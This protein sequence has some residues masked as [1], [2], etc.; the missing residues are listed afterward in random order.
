MST[1]DSAPNNDDPSGQGDGKG[2]RCSPQLWK[3]TRDEWEA[4]ASMSYATAVKIIGER[5]GVPVPSKGACAT[6]AKR[7]NWQKN[8]PSHWCCRRRAS[9]SRRDAPRK[10]CT[11]ASPLPVD[12]ASRQHL[13]R[14][15]AKSSTM[16]PMD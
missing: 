2:V 13:P 9:A 8:D 15:R 11:Q 14:M 4:D 7:N 6:Y 10:G 1:Y 5:L 3:A 16:L 12:L